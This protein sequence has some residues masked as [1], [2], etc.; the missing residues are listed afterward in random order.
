VPLP[1][2]LHRA[3]S[4][5]S[6]TVLSQHRSSPSHTFPFTGNARTRANA[7][8]LVFDL[9]GRLVIDIASR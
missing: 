9:V 1:A 2:V 4:G 3:F 7:N 8:T 6:V 5:Q